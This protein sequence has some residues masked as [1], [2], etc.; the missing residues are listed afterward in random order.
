MAYRGRGRGRGRYFRYAKQGPFELFPDV[1][2][3]DIKN[4]VEE[5]SLVCQIWKFE[6]YWKVSPY[7][8]EETTSKSEHKMPEVERFSDRN[9]PKNKVTRDSLFQTLEV[10]NFP[11]ELTA[12]M[13]GSQGQRSRKKARWNPDIGMQKMFEM[14]QLKVKTGFMVIH[15]LVVDAF[16]NAGG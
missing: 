5:T 15:Y 10:R 6:S 8:L 3:P 7:Y 1:D 11:L 4:E 9:K 12:G 13:K 14:F 16:T 2:L